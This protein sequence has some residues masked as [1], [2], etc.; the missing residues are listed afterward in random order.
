MS[1][2]AAVI[3]PEWD[4]YMSKRHKKG[5]PAGGGVHRSIFTPIKPASTIQI[6]F[7]QAKKLV[8]AIETM[9]SLSA[10]C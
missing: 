7:P 6:R 5:A 9:E 8:F 4:Y 3:R 2:H 1:Q 10:L